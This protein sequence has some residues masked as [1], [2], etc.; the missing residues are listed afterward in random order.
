MVNVQHIKI[1]TRFPGL[2]VKT[3]N[4]RTFNSWSVNSHKRLDTKETKPNIDAKPE[5][6]G[7]MFE[8]FYIERWLFG[9]L[10]PISHLLKNTHGSVLLKLTYVTISRFPQ[11]I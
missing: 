5:N 3:T 4:F 1:L 2:P 10:F 9:I 11:G 6:L 8:F 7:A